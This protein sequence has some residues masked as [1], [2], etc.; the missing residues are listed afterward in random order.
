MEMM[1]FKKYSLVYFEALKSKLPQFDEFEV[2]FLE[3]AYLSS[4]TK[5]KGIIKY[6]L[7]KQLGPQANGIDVNHESLSIEHL[8]SEAEIKNGVN[9][10]VVGSI[11]NLILVDGKTNS[12][13]LKNSSAARKI[14]TLDEMGYPIAKCFIIR[15]TWTEI[16]V[17]ERVRKIAAE[18]YASC[19]M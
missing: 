18:L 16:K 19:A 13:V 17:M 6:I 4:K 10:S 7:S 1:K 5:N 15:G 12:E 14:D 11:G 9:E 8:I 2:K 3:L